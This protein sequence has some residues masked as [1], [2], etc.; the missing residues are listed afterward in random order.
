MITEDQNKALLAVAQAAGQNPDWEAYAAFCFARE[1]GLRKEAF[2]YLETFLQQTAKWRQAQKIAFVT[3]LFP[4]VETIEA[5]DQGPLPHPLSE[6]LVKPTLEA[7]CQDE[8]TD[9]RPFR[10]YGTCFRSVEHLVKAIE[11]DPADDRAGLQ[12]ITGW[13][14]ALYYSLHHL[15]EG[16]IGDP[17]EDLRLADAIQSHIDQLR[18]SALRQTWSDNLAAD[19]SLIQNYID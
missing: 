19:R 15:P 18:D 17:A 3:F 7:W 16:Y 9:S 13:R 1:K 6:R 2:S 8:K 11:L 12:L 5:A 4:L 10:W 14:D